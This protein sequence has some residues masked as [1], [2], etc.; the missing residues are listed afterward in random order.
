MRGQLNVLVE[1]LRGAEV[2]RDDPRS[3]YPLEVADDE[4]VARF[5]LF[6]CALGQTEVPLAV[7]VP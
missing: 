2:R 5:G 4:R 3:V 1:V 6:A 7:V